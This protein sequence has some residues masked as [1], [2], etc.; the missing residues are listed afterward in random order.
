MDARA[1]DAG[2]IWIV[3]FGEPHPGEPARRRPAFVVSAP[4]P[5]HVF[6]VPLTTAR[7]RLDAHVEIEPTP[8]TGLDELSYAQCELCRS[9]S[10][11]R[12]A[13]KLGKAGPDTDRL[14]RDNLMHLMEIG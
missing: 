9:V 7:R 2:D 3:D 12:L 5:R 8:E 6:L 1:P 14:I 4:S 13:H 11:D 10:S